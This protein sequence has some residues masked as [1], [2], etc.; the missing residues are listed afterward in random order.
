MSGPARVA[1][2]G[3]VFLG[4]FGLLYSVGSALGAWPPPPEE[5]FHGVDLAAGFAFGLVLLAAL[6]TEGR[7]DSSHPEPPRRPPL[8]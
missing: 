4:L 1:A 3:A 5:G 6:L 8:R 2:A 7:R